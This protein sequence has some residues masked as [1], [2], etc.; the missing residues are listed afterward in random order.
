MRANG[1]D[2][3]SNDGD[4][5]HGDVAMQIQIYRHLRA[6]ILDGLWVDRDDFPGERDLAARFGVSVITSRAAL[7]RLAVEGYVIRGR[8][9]RTRAV[10]EPPEAKPPAPRVIAE[11]MARDTTITMLERGISVAPAAAC[12]AFGLPLGGSLWQCLRLRTVGG[13]PDIVTQNSQRPE[14]GER[15]SR[16]DLDSKPMLAILRSE[17]LN[18]TTVTRHA[19]VA[20]PPPLVARALQV[21][22]TDVLLVTFVSVYDGEG[23]ILDWVRAYSHPGRREPADV[24]DLATGQWSMSA[25]FSGDS[26]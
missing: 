22:I 21:S 7:E 23:E 25:T 2:E 9:L 1:K 6:E 13:K 11:E 24:L 10:H 3:P 8:G 26:R 17:G 19:G 16:A 12:R 4:V 18:A 5:L 20:M 14:V 15:H